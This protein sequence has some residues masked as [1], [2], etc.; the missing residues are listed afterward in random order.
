MRTSTSSRGPGVA[1]ELQRI[2]I[3]CA[4]RQS[5]ITICI[6]LRE[7]GTRARVLQPRMKMPG[8]AG[9][10]SKDRKSPIDADARWGV[11]FF[12]TVF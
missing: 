1:Y 3:P 9:L 10:T 6:T 12:A 2:M 5:N 8:R 7:N 4:R 11:T